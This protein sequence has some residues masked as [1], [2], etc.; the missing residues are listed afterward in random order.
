MMVM[1]GNNETVADQYLDLESHVL[2]YPDGQFLPYMANFGR[3]A[4]MGAHSA[5]Y[6]WDPAQRKF[7][8][9]S[10]GNR[11]SYDFAYNLAGEAFLFDSDMEWDIGLP[12]YRDVRTAHQVLNGDYGYRDGSGKY[13]SYYI[14]SLPPVRDLGR[15]SPV[16]VETYQSDAYP[17]SFFDSLLE[18][19]WSRGRILFTA[20]TP[21]GATYTARTD[22]A[23]LVHGEPLNVTDLEVGPDGL[24]YFSTGGRNTTG[25]IWRL[26]YTGTVPPAP[27]KTGVLAIVRQAQPLSSWGWA[28]IERAKA[29]MGLNFGVELDRLARNTS[30]DV[31]DR[32]RAI[33]EMQRHGVP[34]SAEMLGALMKDTRAP[35]RAAAVFVAGVQGENARQLAAAGLRDADPMV[36]R[37]AAEALVR[38]GQSPD[39]PSLAPV[40]DIYALLADSDSFVRWAGRVALEHTTR[41]EWA[42]RVLADTNAVSAPEGMLAWIRTRGT[43]SVQPII[44]KA[45]TLMRQ[46]NM[47]ADNKL[48]VIRTFMVATTELPETGVSAAERQQLHTIVAPQFPTG[49]ER[50]NREMALLLGYAGQTAGITEVL[51]AVPPGNTNQKLTLHY[52]YALRVVKT[53]WTPAQKEQLAEVL[54]RTSRWRGGAQFSNFLGQFFE[55]FA[56]I[57]TTDEEKRTLYAR[58]PDFAPIA[59]EEA[60]APGPGRAGAASPAPPATPGATARG[61]GPGTA[62]AP[63]AAAA[64]VGPAAGAGPAAGGRGGR[65]RGGTPIQQRTAGRVLDKGEIFDEVIYTPRTQQPNAPA[66]QLVFESSCASCDEP[67]VHS[68][69]PRK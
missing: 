16:G 36:R 11:N 24:L 61:T 19:D 47:S 40:S 42:G 66:G 22:R 63:P 67:F 44:D 13:P 56:E 52:L 30:A 27:D 62:A 64:G 23:E 41:A 58:A 38:M 35:V 69:L 37:R 12:W 39:R 51:A 5:L 8:V 21:A 3:S 2:K 6:Q 46:A 49:D 14:D 34:P 4:R 10:G 53:G 33:Y 1:V 59:P 31:A 20:L 43:E 17:R 65:G 32:S 25:G 50:L 26:R 28:S 18:A 15:G 55:Q 7:R 60:P 54:G 9:F 57:F 45:M 68:K 48:R 29:T